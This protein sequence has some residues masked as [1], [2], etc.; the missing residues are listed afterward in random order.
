VDPLADAYT[1][2][3]IALGVTGLV[4]PGPVGQGFGLGTSPGARLAAR[5][6]AAR[7]L[8]AGAGIL[9]A[10]R[11]GRGRGWYQAA[12]ATDAVDA[13]IAVV[14]GVTGQLPARRAALVTVLAGGSAVVGFL[15]AGQAPGQAS[16]PS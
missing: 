10:R 15:L 8:V 5:H 2:T 14:A 13:V 16:S 6:I 3:R 12:A 4:A 1:Y 9:V 7:D 11:R